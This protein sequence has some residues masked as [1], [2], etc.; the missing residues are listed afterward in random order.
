MKIEV[1]TK[2][3]SREEL[4]HL[5]NMLKAIAGGSK[6]SVVV[7]SK[8]I[9]EESSPSVGLFDMFGSS[10]ASQATQTDVASQQVS[11]EPKQD[12]F[13][14]FS[15]PES[16]KP[17]AQP[18]VLNDPVLD[19]DSSETTVKRTTARDILEDDRITPY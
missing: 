12:L 8:N 3:D 13:S 1:D 6:E 10:S 9:F 18:I 2:V 4:F 15:S 19:T 7:K 16:T 5:A 14:I 17:A 11:P